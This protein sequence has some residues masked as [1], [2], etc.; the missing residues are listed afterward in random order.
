MPLGK[1][2]S[3]SLTYG[4]STLLSHSPIQLNTLHLLNIA[5]IVGPSHLEEFHH[6]SHD[7]WVLIAGTTGVIYLK[8][9]PNIP[10]MPCIVY[11]CIKICMPFKTIDL[12]GCINNLISISSRYCKLAK[13][14]LATVGISLQT[15]KAVSQEQEWK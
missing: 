1:F 5:S 9:I 4:A 15:S 11:I 14:L 6:C 2:H 13:A 7:S 12:S 3:R 10:K 8:Q